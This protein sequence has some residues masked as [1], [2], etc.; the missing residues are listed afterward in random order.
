ME[1][2]AWIAHLADWPG[3]VW[4]QQSG[5]AYLFVNAT[6][7]LGI[8]LLLGGILPLDWQLLRGRASATLAMLVRSA[9]GGLTL[10]LVTGCWLFTVQPASYLVNA[11]FQYKMGLLALALVNV[12]VQHRCA[13]LRQALAT[14]VVTGA[15]RLCAALSL[16]LWLAVLVAGR[17]IGFV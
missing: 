11:A 7:I 6:H 3:A 10:A 15:V 16:L 5:T 14:G 8:A 9:G 2:G 4:L 17:W 12:L 1:S 13:G